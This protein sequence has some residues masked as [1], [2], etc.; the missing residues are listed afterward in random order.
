MYVCYTVGRLCKV[1]LWFGLWGLYFFSGF[2]KQSKLLFVI[3]L[4]PPI[5]LNNIVAQ[6]SEMSIRIATP[7]RY[8]AV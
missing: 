4:T 2:S 1:I 3:Q 8:C 5:A 7:V 6:Q